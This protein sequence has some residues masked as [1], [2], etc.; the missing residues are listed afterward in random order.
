MLLVIRGEHALGLADESF[1]AGG[2]NQEGRRLE[3]GQADVIRLADVQDNH[4]PLL[5]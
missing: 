4:A 2:R 1:P 5:D 3:R